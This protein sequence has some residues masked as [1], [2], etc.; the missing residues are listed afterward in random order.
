MFRKFNIASFAAAGAEGATLEEL[1]SD[2]WHKGVPSHL[3]NK[4]VA[5]ALASW[6]HNPNE[7][8]GKRTNRRK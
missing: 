8:K 6:K 7:V 5:A 4:G 3:G 1:S 2:T